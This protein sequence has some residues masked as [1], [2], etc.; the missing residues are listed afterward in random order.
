MTTTG[1][2]PLMLVGP[3]SG[4]LVFAILFLRAAGRLR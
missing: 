4:D 3:G 2:A 1:N